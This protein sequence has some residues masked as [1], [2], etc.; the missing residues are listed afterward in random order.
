MRQN[1]KPV[2][3]LFK[4]FTGFLIFLQKESLPPGKFP[5]R[6]FIIVLK[7]PI[8]SADLQSLSQVSFP[9]GKEML[10]C[11]AVYIFA[12]F[13]KAFSL[14]LAAVSAKIKMRAVFA[15][16]RVMHR[17][18]DKIPRFLRLHDFRKTGLPECSESPLIEHEEIAG[19]DA[20]VSL[21]NKLYAADSSHI[22]GFGLSSREHIDEIINMA[23][24]R[25]MP[26]FKIFK[27]KVEDADQKLA[28]SLIREG[29]CTALIRTVE[30]IDA[31][32]E[33]Q[34]FE[35]VF[36]IKSVDLFDITG[37]FAGQHGEDIIRYLVLI[38]KF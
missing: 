31:G 22:A 3:S 16:L 12:A 26:F 18:F 28:V 37:V 33:L 9:F 2:K 17:F 20:A 19:I 38:K 36:L 29:I 4:G 5:S 30:G 11:I 6:I 24:A 23:N 34:P 13:C 7:C 1:K 8:P 35:V 32:N 10:I 25:I 21:D 14:S 27:P 15:F